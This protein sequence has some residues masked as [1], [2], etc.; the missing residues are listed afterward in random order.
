VIRTQIQF[1]ETQA[2]RL[3]ELASARGLSVSELVRNGVDQLLDTSPRSR[4]R[5]DLR[6]RARRL[7]GRFSSRISDL[8]AGHDAHLAKIYGR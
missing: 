5:N 8:A 1:T 4:D 3:R 2:S 6:D 7:A